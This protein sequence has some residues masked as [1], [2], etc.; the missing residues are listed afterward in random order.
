VVRVSGRESLGKAVEVTAHG[1]SH[2]VVV[3]PD[4]MHPGGI[5]SALDVAAA[6]VGL[7]VRSGPPRVAR[8]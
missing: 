3:E 5:L 1:T 8:D 6:L 7:D 2:V 4:T